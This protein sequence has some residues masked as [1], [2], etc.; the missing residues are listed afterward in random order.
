[1]K[2]LFA[3]IGARDVRGP[4]TEKIAGAKQGLGLMENRPENAFRCGPMALDRILL[5]TNQRHGVRK[6]I[7]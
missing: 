4:A 2:V 6:E 7:F 1:M 3:E 5:A